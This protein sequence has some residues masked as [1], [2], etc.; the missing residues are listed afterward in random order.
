MELQRGASP[1]NFRALMYESANEF[2]AAYREVVTRFWTAVTLGEK[3][4]TRI[5]IWTAAAGY[6]Q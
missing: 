2:N 1:I 5:E 3:F 4:S 6:Q